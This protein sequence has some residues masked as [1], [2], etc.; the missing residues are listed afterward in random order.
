[1]NGY[2]GTA[3]YIALCFSAKDE[4]AAEQIAERLAGAGLRVWCNDRGCKLTR[5]TDRERLTNC[6][7]AL[8]LVSAQWIADKVCQA[9]LAAA[10]EL[11]RQTVLLFLDGSDLTGCEMLTPYLGRA[12]RM[13]DYNDEGFSEL[14]ALECITDCKAAPGE[15]TGSGKTGGIFDFFR[16]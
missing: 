16:K 6:R 7:T 14:L 3:D 11:E 5:K 2:Q 9:Q 12:T 1:M 4:E 13:L 15:D 10:C 8:I